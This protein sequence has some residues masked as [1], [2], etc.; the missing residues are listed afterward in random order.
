MLVNGFQ[1]GSSSDV[2]SSGKTYHYVAWKAITGHMTV[3]KYQGDGLDNRDIQ[4]LGMLPQYMMVKADDI[5][6]TLHRCAALGI[7]DSTLR[8]T[9]ATNLTNAIQALQNDGFEVGRH[10]QVNKLGEDFYFAAFADGRPSRGPYAG[11]MVNAQWTNKDGSPLGAAIESSGVPMPV[12]TKVRIGA[13]SYE[14]FGPYMTPTLG[15]IN[16]DQ[17]STGWLNLGSNPRQVVIP[18]MHAAGAPVSVVGQS[19]GRAHGGGFGER[20]QPGHDAQKWRSR[21][22]LRCI[23]F[24]GEPRRVRKG[25]HREWADLAV[26]EPS[27]LSLRAGCLR[28]FFER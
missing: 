24:A 10:D 20:E 17:S 19:L 18:I 22:G 26:R 1:L 7:A 6:G 23:P 11:Y 3:G 2:N 15:N 14:P 27:D 21:S 12:T 25:L 28:D 8:F 13:S 4:G 16:D 5:V 9:A